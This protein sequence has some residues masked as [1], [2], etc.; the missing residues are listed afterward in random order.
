MLYYILFYFWFFFVWLLFNVCLLILIWIPTSLLYYWLPHWLVGTWDVWLSPAPNICLID[1][2][3][4]YSTKN[5]YNWQKGPSSSGSNTL[6]Y[7]STKRSMWNTT[8]RLLL[9]MLKCNPSLRSKKEKEKGGLYSKTVVRIVEGERFPYLYLLQFSSL[10]FLALWWNMMSITFYN[11]P[12]L[13]N[14]L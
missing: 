12:L 11:T 13:Y 8:P 6:S 4:S 14:I 9:R 10:F 3:T 1:Y 7:Y 5:P 2:Y